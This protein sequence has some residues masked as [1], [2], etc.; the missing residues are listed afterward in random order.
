MAAAFT[1][2]TGGEAEL[3]SMGCCTNGVSSAGVYGLPTV[4]FG[5]GSLDQ[6]HSANEFC[7]VEQLTA[8]A[9]IHAR[10]CLEF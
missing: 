7:P 1:A 8:A 10:L 6:A 2:Q 9:A 4:V 5:P 3:F